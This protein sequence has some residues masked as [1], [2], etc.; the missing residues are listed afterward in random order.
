MLCDEAIKISRVLLH[1]RKNICHIFNQMI[2]KLNIL[3]EVFLQGDIAEQPMKSTGIGP[4]MSANY[5]LGMQCCVQGR[6]THE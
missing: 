5:N 2:N 3:L 6:K 1:L 4:G